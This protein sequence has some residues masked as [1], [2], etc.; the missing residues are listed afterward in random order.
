M[1]RNQP[2]ALPTIA[3]WAIYRTT[4][5]A[6]ESV[7]EANSSSRGILWLVPSICLGTFIWATVLVGIFG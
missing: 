3:T 1:T 2:A 5:K 4:S 7:E 6:F